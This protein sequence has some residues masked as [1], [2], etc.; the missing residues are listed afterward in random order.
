MVCI[1]FFEDM[2]HKPGTR[3]WKQDLVLFHIDYYKILTINHQQ[4]LTSV[5]HNFKNG[6][7]NSMGSYEPCVQLHQE[8]YESLLDELNSAEN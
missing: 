7:F 2:K 8:G 1:R 4:L 5:I 3:T 6:M